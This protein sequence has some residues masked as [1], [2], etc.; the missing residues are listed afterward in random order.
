MTTLN[1]RLHRLAAA[2][3][4]LTGLLAASAAPAGEIVG[5]TEADRAL[6]G[7]V[8]AAMLNAAPFHDPLTDVTIRADAGRVLL[9]GWV[10][11]ADHEALARSI[12]MRVD[13]VRAV[14]T[15]VRAWS[16][17]PDY[18]IGLAAPDLLAEPTAAGPM[19]TASPADLDLAAK[20]RASLLQTGAFEPK[21]TELQVRASD[22][23]VSLSGW[24]ASPADEPAV[25]QSALAVPGVT[26]VDS[27]FRAWASE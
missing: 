26:R 20:V 6:A 16:S 24:L 27:W 22:G 4:L 15:Q 10:A 12:A 25:R 3:A 19:S 2:T 11:H 14:S 9:S 5:N 7:K 8:Q 1:P 13:G 23:R 17:D 18:R 21:N